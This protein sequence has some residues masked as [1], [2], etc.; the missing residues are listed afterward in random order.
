MRNTEPGFGWMERFMVRDRA[1]ARR[2][3][4]RILAWDIDKI[5]L[6]HGDPVLADGREVVRRAYAWV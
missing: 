2:Q 6:S 4:D 1:V 3:L 5:V